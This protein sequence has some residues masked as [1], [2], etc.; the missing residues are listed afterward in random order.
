MPSWLIEAGLAVPGDRPDEAP[1]PHALADLPRA[2]PL[3]LCV[4][5]PQLPAALLRLPRTG[6]RDRLIIGFWNWELPVLPASWRVATDFVHEIWVPSAFTA[7]AVAAMLPGT[8]AP[9]LRIVPYPLAV[10]PPRPAAIGRQAFGLPADAVIVLTS[11]N[12][13]SSFVR[14]NPLA[15]IAAFR[16]AFGDRSD[17]MLLLKIGKTEHYADDLAAIRSATGG[18]ANIRIDTRTLASAERHALTACADIVL[19]LHRSE[20]FGLVPAEAMLLGKP[21]VATGWSGNLAFMDAASAAL[22]NYR[23]VPA[24]DPRGVYDEPGARW[25]EPDVADAAARLVQLA[26]DLPGRVA[27][28]A[29]GRAAAQAR[30]GTEKLAEAVRAIGLLPAQNHEPKS[31]R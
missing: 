25:A 21:V 15:A 31:M 17:L 3:I 9:T 14:K 30:L 4:N 20:G 11:L 26:D 28:G 22:V 13:A 1:P 2:A 5:A 23:L 16:A 10:V 18:M 7:A 24:F 27:L 12:L 6:L 19:S 8:N 29:R